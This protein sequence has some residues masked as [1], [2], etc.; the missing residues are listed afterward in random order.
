MLLMAAGIA[1]LLSMVPFHG[2]LVA[3]GRHAAPMALPFALTALPTVVLHTCFRLWEA[4]PA[5]LNGAFVF[6]VCRWTGIAAV[7]LGGLG[8]LGQRRWGALAGYVTLVDWGAGLIALG[9]GTRAGM[10]QMVQLL[11]WRAFSLLLVGVGWGTIFRAA[12][13]RDDLEQSA[14]P[15]RRHPLGVLALILGLLSLAGFPLSPGGLGRWPLLDRTILGQPMSDWPTTTRVLVLAGAAAGLGVVI[16]LGRSL[17]WAAPTREASARASD[18]QGTASGPKA[19]DGEPT[20]SSEVPSAEQEARERGARATRRRQW[21]EALL[22][23][24]T[25]LLALWLLGALALSPGPWIEL[26]RRL[27]GELTFPGS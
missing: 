2:Q 27:V 15:I 16:T 9:L 1:I 13:R 17:A 14:G 6:D 25:S 8:A 19:S 20:P 23:A 5:L 24:G 11:I 3:M 4:H 18:E 22:S 7:F 10:E 26:A 12:G 21:L